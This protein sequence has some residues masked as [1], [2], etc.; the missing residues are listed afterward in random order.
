MINVYIL[1]IWK[2]GRVIW[3]DFRNSNRGWNSSDISEILKVLYTILS[4]NWTF[5][6]NFSVFGESYFR[7][8]SLKPPG[9][10][11]FEAFNSPD[12]WQLLVW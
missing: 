10:V 12:R 5:N 1:S 6:F 3:I 8:L 2:V 7:A 4:D 11:T 9:Y